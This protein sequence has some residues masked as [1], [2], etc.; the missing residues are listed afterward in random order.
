MAKEP[1]FKKRKEKNPVQT[2]IGVAET[3][4]VHGFKGTT[5]DE[6]GLS[7]DDTCAFLEDR[8]WFVFN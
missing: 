5:Y 1:R 2:K 8:V 3:G 7:D 4:T 6:A